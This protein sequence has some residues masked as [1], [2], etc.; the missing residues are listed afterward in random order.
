LAGAFSVGVFTVVVPP[1]GTVSDLLGIG[2]PF[3]CPV[4]A[5]VLRTSV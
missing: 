4:V 5:E 2:T 1:L 3:T